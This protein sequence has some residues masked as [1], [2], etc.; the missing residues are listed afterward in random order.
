MLV[1][2]LEFLQKERVG[3]YDVTCYVVH[4]SE[5]FED[6]IEEVYDESSVASDGRGSVLDDNLLK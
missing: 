1:T 4:E 6:D 3:V 2:F 5:A